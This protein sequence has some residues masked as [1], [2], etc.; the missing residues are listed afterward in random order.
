MKTLKQLVEE[1]GSSDVSYKITA[2][3]GQVMIAVDGLM[4]SLRKP[5]F[6]L[7]SM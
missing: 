5:T 1:L 2:Q 4:H 7:S 6:G 3:D